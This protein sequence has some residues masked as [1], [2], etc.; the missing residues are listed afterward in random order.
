MK[1][2]FHK[3][4]GQEDLL[5]DGE[6]FSHLY[7]SRRTKKTATLLFSNLMDSKLYIYSHVQIKK[8]SA[9][10]KLTGEIPYLREKK[11]T[12]IIWSITNSKTI[13]DALPFLNQLGVAKLTLFYS[14]NSQMDKKIP[15]ERFYNI[16][17][18]SCE[19]C[20]RNDLMKIEVLSNLQKVKELYPQA[21]L[22]DFHGKNIS[23]EIN[24]SQGVIIGPEGGF[25][26]EEKD[27]FCG[28]VY[29]LGKNI[30]KSE[31]AA[32]HLASL[33]YI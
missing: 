12:Y 20:G 2:S 21:S 32:I 1:F 23:L 27:K 31:C 13:G 6:L 5:V 3:N 16:L 19:Q 29:S 11:C 10:L 18:Q 15:M 33:A 14:H 24:F 8:Q 7:R 17:I 22:I 26:Q 9:I 30:L 4:S 25:A 28:E